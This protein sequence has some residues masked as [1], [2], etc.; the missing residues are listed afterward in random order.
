MRQKSYLQVV[1]C[2]FSVIAVAHALRLLN[3]WPVQIGSFTVPLW[4]SWLAI[5]FAAFMAY[6][7]FKQI[8]KK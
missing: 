4:L 1:A 5:F 6:Q 7:G 3:R 2:I 8:D